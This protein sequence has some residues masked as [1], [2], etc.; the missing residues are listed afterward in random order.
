MKNPLETY[1]SCARLVFSVEPTEPNELWDEFSEFEEKL[2]EFY[3]SLLCKNCSQ[4]LTDPCYP[5]KNHFSCQHRVCLDCI[6]KNRSTLTNCKMCSDFTLFEKSNQTKLIIKLFQELCELIKGSWIYDYIQ[7]RTN[8]DTGQSS[9]PTLVEIIEYGVNYGR[10]SIVVEDD[11][12]SDENSNS[13]VAKQQSPQSVPYNSQTFPNLSPLSPASPNNIPTQIVQSPEQF[14]L[15]PV[16]PIQALPIV[17]S[18]PSPP[19]PPHTLPVLA[20]NT[21]VSQ[22]IQ[23][24]APIVQS[25][26]AP[27]STSKYSA[28]SQ[29]PLLKQ[30][31][32]ISQHVPMRHV[33]PQPPMT[34]HNVTKSIMSPIKIQQQQQ[35]QQQAPTIYSVMYTGSGN[36]ITLKRKTTD[37][38]VASAD[39]KSTNNN[40]SG[41]HTNLC[42]IFIQLFY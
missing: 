24:Q 6:G 38:T 26:L 5:K 31:S 7:R 25:Q 34:T 2:R 3:E 41:F 12:S 8:Y 15:L 37:E 36:K 14:T 27:P 4:V 20:N 42:S 29:P 17:S 40:V 30:S 35:H 18:S 10:I 1:I 13:S 9:G 11:T 33:T 39:V 19:Q 16:E 28:P 23:Y 32:F 21:A 22:L